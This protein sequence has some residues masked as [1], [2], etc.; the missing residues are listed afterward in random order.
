MSCPE[1]VFLSYL[2]LKQKLS[3]FDFHPYKEGRSFFQVTT[4]TCHVPELIYTFS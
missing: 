2:P 4:T 3:S 1:I